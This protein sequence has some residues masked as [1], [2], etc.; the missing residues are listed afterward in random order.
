MTQTI[1]PDARFDWVGWLGQR[2][3]RSAQLTKRTREELE[4]FFVTVSCMTKKS[5]RIDGW[6]GPK[7]A[8]QRVDEAA[9]EYIRGHVPG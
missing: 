1:R 7:K 4:Q 2:D 5:V 8:Q 3:V 6:D 9:R